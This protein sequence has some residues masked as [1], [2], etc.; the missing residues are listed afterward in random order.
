MDETRSDTATAPGGLE[1]RHAG[2][3]GLVSRRLVVFLAVGIASSL[4][5]LAV[6]SAAV[7]LGGLSVVPAAFLGFVAG[8]AVS[9]A[10]NT[11]LT[12]KAKSDTG[13]FTRFMIVVLVGMA[14]NQALAFVLDRLGAHYVVVWLAV[15][16]LIPAINYV[17]HSLFTYRERKP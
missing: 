5:Y 7:E 1:P 16:T 4:A 10:G 12:F 6:L 2:L 14:L 11:L 17:G 8:T 13:T 15:F 9:Y 3:R